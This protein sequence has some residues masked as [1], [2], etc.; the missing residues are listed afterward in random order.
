MCIRDS[1]WIGTHST[2]QQRS[3]R[4]YNTSE[5]DKVHEEEGYSIRYILLAL[6][7]VTVL[8]QMVAQPWWSGTA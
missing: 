4:Q 5:R 7:I 3:T 8:S 2:E 1:N 6:S